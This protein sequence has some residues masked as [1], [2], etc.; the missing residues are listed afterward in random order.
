MSVFLFNFVCVFSILLVIYPKIE[1]TSKTF[2]NIILAKYYIWKS[3][4]YIIDYMDTDNIAFRINYQ[5]NPAYKVTML[6]IYLMQIAPD[7]HFVHQISGYIEEAN[8]EASLFYTPSIRMIMKRYFKKLSVDILTHDSICYGIQF[9]NR[10]KLDK[11]FINYQDN[12][13]EK[14]IMKSYESIWGI[15]HG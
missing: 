14:C 3:R 4:R 7:L 5:F 13:L 6:D 2:L 8:N 10:A 1:S 12:T 11:D 9:L 15:Y